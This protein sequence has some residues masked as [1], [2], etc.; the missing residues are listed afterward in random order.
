[1]A[2]LSELL[3]EVRAAAARF[4][5]DR[6]SGDDCVRLADELARA[7]NAC[8]AAAA[9]AAARAVACGRGDVEWVARTTGATPSQARE[10]LTTTAALAECEATSSAVASGTCR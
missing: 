7:A 3:V 9:R 5:A 10:S 8:T 1:M 2:R 4:E 6:W